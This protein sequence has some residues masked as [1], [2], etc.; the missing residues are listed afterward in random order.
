MKKEE[1]YIACKS[2]VPYNQLC[3]YANAW[4]RINEKEI[5]LAIIPSGGPV[6]EISSNNNEVFILFK[7]YED[8]KNFNTWFGTNYTENMHPPPNIALYSIEYKYLEDI[9]YTEK[10]KQFFEIF[11]WIHQNCSGRFYKNRNMFFFEN[12]SDITAF[13]LKWV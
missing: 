13:K 10:E 7:N 6:I 11:C 1:T 12:I 2:S 8:Q 9:E 4:S 3:F 5:K